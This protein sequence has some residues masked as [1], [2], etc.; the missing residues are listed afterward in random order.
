MDVPVVATVSGSAGNVLSGMI[1]VIASSLIGI[2]Q[3]INLNPLVNGVDAET[4]QALRT[5]FQGFLA[6]RS[7]ATLAA[8]QNAISNVRQ[9]LTAVIQENTAADGSYSPGC[10]MVIL[11]DGSGS[12]SADLLAS[13]TSAVD[14][15]RPIGSTFSVL[16]PQITF[17]NVSLTATISSAGQL[18]Q[19]ISAIESSIISYL[20]SLPIGRPASITRV[21]QHAYI[22][23]DVI[24]NISSIRLN[25]A[26]ADVAPARFGVIKAGTIVVD[27]HDR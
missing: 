25:D 15:V 26:A 6:S 5:R 20:D 1:N 2:D 16:P 27:T 3:V 19:I 4:D 17:V 7:R 22:N 18:T 12:P 14:F 10:F 23:S 13:V 11:D 9:N 8:I 24:D 21:A